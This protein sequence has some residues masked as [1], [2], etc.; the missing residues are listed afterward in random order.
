MVEESA[1]DP[2]LFLYTL[3]AQLHEAKGIDIEPSSTA[4]LLSF[5]RKF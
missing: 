2:P 1:V 3:L 4:G 5:A